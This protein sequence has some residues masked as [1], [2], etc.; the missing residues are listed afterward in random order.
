[1]VA[2]DLGRRYCTHEA[3]GT[4]DRV[5]SPELKTVI[6][7]L[8]VINRFRFA[9]GRA[10]SAGNGFG[11]CR[12][13]FEKELLMKRLQS[14]KGFTLVELLVVIGI[15]ALLISILLPSLNRAREAANRIKC[16]SN[17][18]QIGLAMKMYSNGEPRT[19]AYPRTVWAGAT[20]STATWASPGSGNDTGIATG[21]N[22]SPFN[23][24]GTNGGASANDVSA[25]M[26]LILRTQEI[27][28]D[29]FICPSS[30]ADR[31][32]IASG[33][34]VQNYT[35]WAPNTASTNSISKSLSYSY[36][37]PYPN[38]NAI[39]GGFSWNDS[40]TSDFAIMA[41]INPGITGTTATPTVTTVT[42]SSAGNSQRLANSLNHDQ[43]GQ[44]VLFAD[45]HVDWAAS[46]WVGV[47]GD[48]IYGAKTGSTA[49]QAQTL[50]VAGTATL[51]PYDGN[52]TILLPTD[53]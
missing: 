22:P 36:Q 12:T 34:T 8:I 19:N 15:I 7:S 17:L 26:F 43:D 16:A 45:D 30:N 37:N 33:S 52:D 46:V 39:N 2:G 21:S 1:M 6:I 32:V 50:G 5:P 4:G 48:N 18:R 51:S 31:F 42:Q 44:N 10:V 38:Q 11:E 49:T 9:D 29:V 25:A 20:V 27:T 35:N 40:I 28:P 41:D 14:T 24:A 3:D 53:D 13:I 47:Q 23:S